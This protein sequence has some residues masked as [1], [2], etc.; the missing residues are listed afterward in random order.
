MTKF[1][2]EHLIVCRIAMEGYSRFPVTDV[3][4]S[5]IS[6]PIC[7][8][9]FHSFD[10]ALLTLQELIKTNRKPGRL[11]T[12][13]LPY[14]NIEDRW[15]AE[16]ECH[17]SVPLTGPPS[18]RWRISSPG[19]YQPLLT[20]TRP[21]HCGNLFSIKFRF[22]AETQIQ[23]PTSEG[24]LESSWYPTLPYYETVSIFNEK[25]SFL[26]PAEVVP[27]PETAEP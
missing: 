7:D 8:M 14:L 4:V 16:S 13:D 10:D 1:S 22:N 12:S 19:E 23:V 24:V 5:T 18:Q 20:Q 15:R 11:I 2:V 25:I 26:R 27:G 17:S 9:R 3:D 6:F 21:T